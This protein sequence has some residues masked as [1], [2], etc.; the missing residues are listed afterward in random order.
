M[1]N[2]RTSYSRSRSPR[3]LLTPIPEAPDCA[4]RKGFPP[5]TES[6]ESGAVTPRQDECIACERAAPEWCKVKD[7][8][9]D[10]RVRGRLTLKASANHMGAMRAVCNVQHGVL[11][12]SVAERDG[13]TVV[14]AEVPVEDLAVGL[15]RGR[16]D[17]FTI[18]TLHKGKIYDEIYC[19]ADNQVKR[20]KWI[21]VFRRM[22][23]AIF[24]LQ[25]GE[26]ALLGTTV[27]NG[28][29]RAVP[30]ARTPHHHAL[31]WVP[32]Y[33]GGVASYMAKTFP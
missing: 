14:V 6:A 1:S 22:G 13:N 8:P 17:M 12:L 15:Q 19:F 2:T 29:S 10:R 23:V 30:A 21:A 18:A 20:N 31:S 26:R 5:H 27:H 16:A 25:Q 3:A 24:D 11:T 9:S 32:A 4:S 28:G 7:W 33:N